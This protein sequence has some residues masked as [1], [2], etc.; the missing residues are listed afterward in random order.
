MAA[1]HRATYRIHNTCKFHQH[2][3]A[4]GLDDPSMV[5][6]NAGIDQ[7][8]AVR[9]EGS[10]SPHLIG[11]HQA[12]VTDHIGS[13]NGRKPSLQGF[14]HRLVVNPSCCCQRDK[15]A[16]DQPSPQAGTSRSWPA[17]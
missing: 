12:A 8:A 5:L 6:G 1:L 3:V 11:A 9:L 17:R 2:T 7:F 13:Q 15:F 10:E 16:R 4:G 14:F